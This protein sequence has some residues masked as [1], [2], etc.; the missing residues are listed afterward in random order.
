MKRKYKI[1]IVVIGILL[2]ISSLIY[3]SFAYFKKTRVQSNSNIAK[4]GCFD[5]EFSDAGNVD[6][7]STYPISDKEGFKVL[8]Y[9][10]TI[11]NVCDS[12]SEYQINLESMN[13]DDSKSLPIRYVRT[14]LAE[15]GLIITNSL[16]SSNDVVE[17]I[18]DGAYESHRLYSDILRSNESIT[19][20]FRMW[21]DKDTPAI[22]EVM[23]AFY[24]ARISVEFTYMHNKFKDSGTLMQTSLESTDGFWAHRSD[25]ASV[26]IEDSIYEVENASY[27][28]DVSAAQD[29]SVMS[30]LVN[31]GDDTFTLYLQGDGGVKA[32]EYSIDL[33]REFTSLKNVEGIENLDL[34]ETRYLTDAF[35][36]CTALE[37]LNWDLS[38]MNTSKLN[39]IDSLFRN[40]TNLKTI[41]IK[42]FDTSNVKVFYSLFS[43]CESLENLTLDSL[44]VKSA[45]NL[46][47]M[48]YNCNSL[49]S[50]DLS[51]FDTSNVTDMSLM[52]AYNYV[53]TNIDV[54]GFNTTNVQTFKDM[55]YNC[56]SL[57]K[58]DVSNFNTA[59]ASDFSNMFYDC[60]QLI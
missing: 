10:F 43:G 35:R 55:F 39:N 6:L 58:I 47:R 30:Y 41:N 2:L 7:G 11:T 4:V 44:N 24:E 45:Q 14:S 26:V 51:H 60:E 52:F 54:S 29:N 22:D 37:E 40:C 18:I 34:S 21:V 57:K 27:S 19:Y 32:N 49:K 53:L 9:T 59:S 13:I 33:F 5:I 3:T 12:W 8:P 46:S 28:Y 50:I 48:F 23:N 17:P 25:I 1:V 15:N 31:N 38:V 36:G 42:W 16:L 56:E 20:E